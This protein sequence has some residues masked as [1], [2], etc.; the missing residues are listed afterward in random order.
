MGIFLNYSVTTRNL[1]GKLDK[2]KN[3]RRGRQPSSPKIPLRC[4]F[5]VPRTR[6][7][8]IQLLQYVARAMYHNCSVIAVELQCVARAMYRYYS[9]IAV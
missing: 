4:M 9:V 8:R 3:L 7:A 6:V 2:N 1:K 5:H